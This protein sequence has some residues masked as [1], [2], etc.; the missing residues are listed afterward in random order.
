MN[1]KRM[2]IK[3]MKIKS[4]RTKSTKT[5]RILSIIMMMV[6]V[7][8][9]ILSG[10]FVPA[11]K[12]ATPELGTVKVRVVDNVP[13]L[14]TEKSYL[15]ADYQEPFGEILPLTEVLI[16]E[17]LTMRGALEKALAAKNIT[18][19]GAVNY[20]SGIGPVTS[21]DGGRTV[22]KLSEFDSG[23]Q[24]GWMASLNDWFIN[25]GA[26]TFTVKDGDVV[27]F[28]YICNLGV[29]LGAGFGDGDTS[30]KALTVNKGILS[31]SFAPGTQN[32]TLTLPAVTTILVTPTAANRNNKVTIQSGEA[33]YRSTDE[34][35]VVNGQEITVTCG[36]D[37][38]KITIAI[39][40]D[41]Q[42]SAD[43]VRALIT[44]LPAV[45][46][47]TLT[48]KEQV[49]AAR[50]A[51][52]AL[53]AEQ[54][55]LIDNLSVLTA[56][57][58]KI[59]E[60]LNPGEST[61]RNYKHDFLLSTLSLEMKEGERKEVV[62][63]DTPRVGNEDGAYNRTDLVTEVI[64]GSDVVSVEKDNPDG[65]VTGTRYYVKGHKEGIARIKISYPGYEGQTTVLA[66][67]VTKAV[68]AGPALSTDIELSKYDILYFTGDSMD[69]SFKV[70]TDPDATVAAVLNGVQS[71]AADG[72]I[73]VKLKDGYNPIVLTSSKAA[74]KTT[75]IYNL[76]AKK[77]AYTVENVTRPGS[78][79]CRF[80]RC[81]VQ[82][83]R[84]QPNG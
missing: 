29:D 22:T 48:N 81:S 14:A 79:E 16:T 4:M 69:Y 83:G 34:I 37:T 2:K 63:F 40:S 47:L 68:P 17:G 54:K 24:S 30:V 6:L 80:D 44:A 56:A 11:V 67:N 25:A 73:T 1:A 9:N 75:K 41:D 26:N 59:T 76:R 77:I 82:D 36:T 53:S 18:V 55:A 71:A 5:Q 21:V 20:V 32:Y 38:Y 33:T 8:T 60:L 10:L 27:E 52:N 57:E 49:E 50:T 84:G 62:L 66:V 15:P 35:A 42:A 7:L 23:M 13:R 61:A 74:G 58:E 78:L 3:S 31:P 19:F 46:Q 70:A 28:W 72:R 45:D 39:S 43:A 51:Y 12:A 64:E 65:T